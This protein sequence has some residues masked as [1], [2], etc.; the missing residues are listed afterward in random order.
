MLQEFLEYL[1]ALPS[2]IP[3]LGQQRNGNMISPMR[4][5]PSWELSHIPWLGHF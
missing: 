4:G 3:L 1:G 2:I 5:V